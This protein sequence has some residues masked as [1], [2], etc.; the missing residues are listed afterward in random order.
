MMDRPAALRAASIMLL[1]LIGGCRP[2]IEQPAPARGARAEYLREARKQQPPA[3]LKQWEAAAADALS[4][5][6]AVRAP[7][8]ETLDLSV[9]RRSAVAYRLELKRLQKVEVEIQAP[10]LKGGGVLI[11]LLELRD[12]APARTV[13]SGRRGDHTFRTTAPRDGTYVLRVQPELGFGGL[14]RLAIGG[15]IEREPPPVASGIVFPVEGKDRSAI[16]SFFGD[17]R[18]GGSRSHRGV[19]IFA[20][21]GTPVVAAADGVVQTVATTPVGGRIVWLRADALQL[22]FYYAH[23][24]EQTVRQGER[25]SAGA[26]LG[27]VGNTGNATGTSPHLHFGVYAV[28]NRA[29]DPVAYFGGSDVRLAGRP[30]DGASAGVDPGALGTWRRA[31]DGVRL[32]TSPDLAAA[33]VAELPKHTGVRL[34]GSGSDWVRVHLAD[35]V[36][37]FIQPSDIHRAETAIER[38]QASH[39]LVLREELDRAS[40][41]LGVIPAGATIEVLAVY[42]DHA[43]VRGPDGRTGWTAN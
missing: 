43:Y 40:A 1:V 39:E 22:T 20:A 8:R 27:R 12:E 26:M 24:D 16:R 4:S 33:I 36:A 14:Y 38:R 9:P 7:F 30:L 28:G 13:A 19:D 21:R 31:G 41:A 11:E 6:P 18:D 10:S 23:L 42:G 32:R 35:G 2:Y 34:V 5:P 3:L 25:V 17:S 15:S 29:L 37:G